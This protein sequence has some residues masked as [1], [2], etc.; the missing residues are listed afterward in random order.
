VLVDEPAKDVLFVKSRLSMITRCLSTAA[1]AVALLGATGTPQTSVQ[2]VAVADLPAPGQSV[3]DPVGPGGAAD[4]WSYTAVVSESQGLVLKDLHFGP[5]LVA[6]SISVPYIRQ[7][8]AGAPAGQAAN[9]HLSVSPIAGDAM[10]AT[11]TGFRC[12]AGDEAQHAGVSATYNVTGIAGQRYIVQQSYRFDPLDP[13][14]RCE[15]TESVPCVR[16]WPAV[17][18]AIPG[19]PPQ[20]QGIGLETV[21]RLDI[22]P[23]AV[24]SGVADVI[25]DTP[26]G[27]AVDDLGSSGRLKRED[28]KTMI[29]KGERNRWDNWHQT[30]RG[31]VGLPS[32]LS[33]GCSECVHAHWSWSTLVNPSKC[34][35]AA[36]KEDCWTDG[37]PE[38]LDGSKQTALAGWAKAQEG[39]EQP[40]NWRDLVDPKSSDASE[41]TQSDRPVLYWDVA[42]TVATSPQAGVSIDGADYAA[43]DAAWPQLADKKHGGNGSMFLVPA[44]R[45]TST[46]APGNSGEAALRPDF[47]HAHETSAALLRYPAGYLLPV[48]ISLSPRL[49]RPDQGPYYL[50]V[51]TSGA[52]LLNPDRLRRSTDGGA[53]WVRVYDDAMECT[54]P[55][56]LFDPTSVSSAPDC[57]KVKQ[58]SDRQLLT[59]QPDRASM[60]AL[61]VFDRPVQAGDV[62]LE[63]DA[64]PDGLASY[65]LATGGIAS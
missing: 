10:Q 34:G 39:E 62:Q 64:A 60:I 61:L 43:G 18:W 23:D 17:T 24:G 49:Q 27:T 37:K 29:D 51:K 20:D 6:R 46:D 26:D 40:S 36:V 4:G 28:V 63:L 30:G 41:M 16:F 12:N 32:P 50:R 11:L 58:L 54:L 57:S 21:Q 65:Q 15:P 42:S 19:S 35:L 1:F 47:A 45:F 22:D 31:A 5:R 25:A 56:T 9:G 13:K 53:P 8:G 48:S 2:T 14:E 7:L 38:I 55:S 44:R 33:A 59:Y 52:Q 3:C